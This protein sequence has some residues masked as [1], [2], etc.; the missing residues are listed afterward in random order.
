MRWWLDWWANRDIWWWIWWAAGR[1]RALL[2]AY[3]SRRSESSPTAASSTHAVWTVWITSISFIVVGCLKSS[4][5]VFH[6]CFVGEVEP[7]CLQIEKREEDEWLI[8]CHG[9]DFKLKSHHALAIA[10]VEVTIK[11]AMTVQLHRVAY[12][13]RLYGCCGVDSKDDYGVAVHRDREGREMNCTFD[14]ESACRHPMSAV[15][16]SANFGLN[17]EMKDLLKLDICLRFF[18]CFWNGR[19][20]KK[21]FVWW[22]WDKSRDTL[23]IFI[24]QFHYLQQTH[25]DNSVVSK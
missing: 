19:S 24:Y 18:V 20:L 11:V 12:H 13:H 8:N 1:L 5:Y 3:R 4:P 10:Y 7:T 25:F 6:M 14:S 15:M 17:Y 22:Q 9:I 23:A 16:T 2:G 21:E